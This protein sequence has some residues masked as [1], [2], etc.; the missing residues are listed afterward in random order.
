[1]KKIG[2]LLVILSLILGACCKQ[3]PVAPAAIP[4]EPPRSADSAY[5]ML[6]KTQEGILELSLP[7]YLQGVLLAEM[8]ADFPMEALKAQAIAARTFALRKAEAAKHPDAHVCSESSCCQ[9]WLSP[10]DCDEETRNRLTAAVSDTDGL[11]LT[12][13]GKLI[14]ATF[15]SCSGG[16]TEQAAAVWG[17]DIPY[18]QAV[19]SPGEESAPVYEEVL[20]FSPEEFRERFLQSYPQAELT[21]APEAWISHIHYTSGG[22]IDHL[23][24]GGVELR[25]TELRRIF[26]LRS[27]RLQI[28]VSQEALSFCSYGY[29]HRVGLSQYGA[30]A[31]AEAGKNCEEILL[32][33]YQGT[34]IC[35][36]SPEKKPRL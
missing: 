29:G 31:M 30:C 22:G 15:F 13:G 4:E 12:Y 25:G 26:G 5:T 9:G 28:S 17:T 10:E 32:Y 1:M 3:S 24:I 27:T 18:L 2:L 34:A 16:R 33:Y 11:V 7:T 19:D 21:A 23:Q 35:R 36:L 6:V 14:D 20:S 8:P